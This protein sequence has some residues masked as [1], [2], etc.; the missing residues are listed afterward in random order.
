[1]DP[2]FVRTNLLAFTSELIQLGIT[3][4]PDYDP[5]EQNGAQVASAV[6]HHTH[7]FTPAVVSACLDRDAGVVDDETARLL[8]QAE[9]LLAWC[10]RG[11]GSHAYERAEDRVRAHLTLAACRRVLNILHAVRA[12]SILVAMGSLTRSDVS[13]VAEAVT[14]WHAGATLAQ[15]LDRFR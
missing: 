9:P 12:D 8:L 11:C 3:G 5:L 10:P 15:A 4:H 7:L 13:T 6:L 2:V 1:M 14:E